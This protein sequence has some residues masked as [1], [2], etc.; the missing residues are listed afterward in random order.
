M[1]PRSVICAIAIAIS[2]TACRDKSNETTVNNY[3]PTNQPAY[4]VGPEATQ[5]NIGVAVNGQGNLTAIDLETGEPIPGLIAQIDVA[6]SGTSNVTFVTLKSIP[7]PP[8]PPP[9]VKE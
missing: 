9:E 2:L 6:V 8:P 4:V 1:M 7:P 3:A 5:A